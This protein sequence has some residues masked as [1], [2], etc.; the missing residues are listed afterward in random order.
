MRR[1][2]GAESNQ[3]RSCKILPTKKLSKSSRGKIKPRNC[4][5]RTITADSKLMR[6]ILGIRNVQTRE[7]GTMIDIN[8]V[9]PG[10]K[11]EMGDMLNE[12]TS[13]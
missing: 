8:I 2:P 5:F 10:T 12:A 13:R 11:V 4:V 6:E 9:I 3:N 7:T 1:K